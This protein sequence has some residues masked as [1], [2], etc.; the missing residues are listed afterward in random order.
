[1]PTWNYVAVHAYGRLEIM[2]DEMELKALLDRM[3][4]AYEATEPA[5]WRL[6]E[7]G[8]YIDRLLPQIVGFRIPISRLE[9]KWKLN[10]NRPADQRERVIGVLSQQRDDNSQEIARLMRELPS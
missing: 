1:M 10:Q 2:Q 6:S 4:Q 9:G 3:V 7:S 8:E 5:P